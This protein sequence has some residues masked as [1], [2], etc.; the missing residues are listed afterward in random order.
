MFNGTPTRY[1][2]CL[3]RISLVARIVT[4]HFCNLCP[5]STPHPPPQNRLM[6]SSG[7]ALLDEMADGEA[8][9]VE[10]FWFEAPSFRRTEPSLRTVRKYRFWFANA[11]LKEKV[12]LGMGGSIIS[13]L[14]LSG[15]HLI[16]APTYH[17]PH[18]QAFA[19]RCDCLPQI[20]RPTQGVLLL[21]VGRPL[22]E[23]VATGDGDGGF[24]PP[25]GGD[26]GQALAPRR[27]ETSRAHP[28]GQG[29]GESEGAAEGRGAGAADGGSRLVRRYRLPR[30]GRIDLRAQGRARLVGAQ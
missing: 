18:R 9:R 1:H 20:G 16:F 4:R 7:R 21:H 2:H 8:L 15:H 28:Q 17:M 10:A 27:R 6:C 12:G 30:A 26:A 24:T 3:I 13:C 19:L 14:S 11:T 25:A 23:V 29:E 22:A 5:I